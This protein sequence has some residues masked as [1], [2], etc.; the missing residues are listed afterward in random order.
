[1]I[2]KTIWY[3]DRLLKWNMNKQIH[4]I[5]ILVAGGD[6]VIGSALVN[7]FC[8]IGYIVIATSRKPNSNCQLK[9]D[10]E[11]V[12]VFLKNSPPKVDILIIAAGITRFEECE[13]SPEKAKLVNVHAP[14][15]LANHYSGSGA[16]VLFFSTS[17]VFNGQYPFRKADEKPDGASIYGKLK[18]EAENE[19]LKLNQQ[20]AILRLSKVFSKQSNLFSQWKEDLIKGKQIYCFSNQ[21]VSP[22]TLTGVIKVVGEL[23][24]RK[25]VGIF[26]FS[27]T[28]DV[29]YW[30]IGSYINETFANSN[31]QVHGVKAEEKGIPSS[32]IFEFN[33]FDTTRVNN[34]L[35]II[36]PK[37]LDFVD[38]IL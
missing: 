16:Y 10:F 2:S 24:Q 32:Q 8:D 26:Q 1:M 12:D 18:A 30:D 6:G 37:P 36:I 23:L 29:S 31:G 28:G 9:L 11:Q 25:L 20:I 34:E 22:I 14:V 33:S 15:K 19:L 17:A 13:A 35:G 3:S 4:E 38:E 21:F 5:I 27:A 7:Y